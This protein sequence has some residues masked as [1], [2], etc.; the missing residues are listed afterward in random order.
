MAKGRQRV[1][2]VRGDP[3][4]L[5]SE[6]TSGA[7]EPAPTTASDGIDT[8]DQ[9]NFVV[10]IDLGGAVSLEVTVWGYLYDEVDPTPNAGWFKVH[11]GT[12][13]V[14]AADGYTTWVESFDCPGLDR[15]YAQIHDINTYSSTIKKFERAV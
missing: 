6:R 8:R 14:K 13:E 1:E 2:L 11:F 12:Y 4:T 10:G 3:I 7:D 15:A 9:L 5:Y